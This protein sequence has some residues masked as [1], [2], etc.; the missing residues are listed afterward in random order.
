MKKLKECF[1]AHFLAKVKYR[2]GFFVANILIK[3]T[4]PSL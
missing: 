3:A 2:S 1:Y 4:V